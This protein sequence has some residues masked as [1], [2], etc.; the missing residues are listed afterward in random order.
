MEPRR[1]EPLTSAVQ[2]RR[3]ALLDLSEVCKVAANKRISTLSLFL[4]FQKIYSGCCTVAALK[5]LSTSLLYTSVNLRLAYALR[6]HRPEV[7]PMA[8]RKQDARQAT[9]RPYEYWTSKV[10]RS[11]SRPET[12]ALATARLID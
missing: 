9:S 4:V 8:E 10:R 12:S 3:H 6:A 11:K 2:R 7:E 5:V 1:L